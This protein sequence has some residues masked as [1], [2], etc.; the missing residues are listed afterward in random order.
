VVILTAGC[1][2]SLDAAGISRVVYGAV[3]WAIYAIYLGRL[4][5]FRFG[6]LMNVYARSG[7]CA[8]AAGVPLAIAR[9]QG[10]EPGLIALLALSGAGVLAWLAALMATR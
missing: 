9:W 8:L 10:L 3:W 7:L 6:A 1:F 5:G 2:I 4:I